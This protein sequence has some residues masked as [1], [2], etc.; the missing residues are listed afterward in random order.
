[1]RSGLRRLRKRAG[2]SIPL[3]AAGRDSVAIRAALISPK[4][5][6]VEAVVD[7]DEKS[8]MPDEPKV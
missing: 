4:P 8:P 2:R 6:L 5:V 1:M 3:R 7:T